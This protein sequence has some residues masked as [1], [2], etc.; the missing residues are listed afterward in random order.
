MSYF[1]FYF[2]DLTW[3]LFI[4]LHK[5]TQYNDNDAI[6]TN[7]KFS[8]SILKNLNTPFWY[9]NCEWTP[10]VFEILSYGMIDV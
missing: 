10:Y 6:E 9:T 5:R 4:Y 7:P 2:I 8:F 3:Q 1:Y